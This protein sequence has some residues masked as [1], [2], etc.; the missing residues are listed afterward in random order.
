M[1]GRHTG[2]SPPFTGRRLSERLACAPSVAACRRISI[3]GAILFVSTW[4]PV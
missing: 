1:Q 3:S 2:G 4:G